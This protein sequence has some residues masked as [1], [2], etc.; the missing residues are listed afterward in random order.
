MVVFFF[1]FPSVAGKL[2]SP[3]F[4]NTFLSRLLYSYTLFWGSKL[5]TLVFKGHINQPSLFYAKYG[6]WKCLLSNCSGGLNFH[7]GYLEIDLSFLFFFFCQ[8]QHFSKAFERCRC[9]LHY[10]SGWKR[11][12]V[13]ETSAEL[14]VFAVLGTLL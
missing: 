12:S 9:C 14:I 10:C 13:L 4:G 1:L 2:K 11:Q 6:K 7:Y 5:H 3:N 8:V